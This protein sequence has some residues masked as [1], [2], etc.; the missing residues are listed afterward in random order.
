M[1]RHS[2]WYITWIISLNIL[3]Y[4]SMKWVLF[5]PIFQMGKLRLMLSKI[6]K[7]IQLELILE[8]RKF[9]SQEPSLF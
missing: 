4:N 1:C 5:F 9:R 6:P 3:N 7:I 8:T 2:D